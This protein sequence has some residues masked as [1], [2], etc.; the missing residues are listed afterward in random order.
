[1]LDWFAGAVSSANAVKEISQALVSIRDES[2]VKERVF[3]LNN[4]LLDLQQQLMSAQLQQMDLI[5]RIE[6]LERE[7]RLS[8][9]ATDFSDEYVVHRFTT[10][11]H[12]YIA[13]TQVDSADTEKTYFCSRC[14]ENG[15]RI[16]LHGAARL[17]CPECKTKIWTRS[18]APAVRYTTA[19][20]PFW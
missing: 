11:T 10:G 8:Q 7:R 20:R 3:E 9:S 2:I 4:C 17:D 14:F 13:K 1:M 6:E 5:K 16:T 19:R 15:K 12:A 18:S